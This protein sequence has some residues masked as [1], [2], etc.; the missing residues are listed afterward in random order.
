MS[1]GTK[2]FDQAGLAQAMRDEAKADSPA[3]SAALHARII[4]GISERSR[5]P[6]GAI[7]EVEEAGPWRIAFSRAMS[8]R[9]LAAAAVLVLGI[10]LAIRWHSGSGNTQAIVPAPQPQPTVVVPVPNPGVSP[11]MAGQPAATP[12]VATL[13]D[14][15]QELAEFVKGRFQMMLV[16]K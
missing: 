13:G 5:R 6:D 15:A 10:S 14:D 7:D 11:I 2:L 16:E 9:V 3:F 4:G 12:S 8:W 1:D